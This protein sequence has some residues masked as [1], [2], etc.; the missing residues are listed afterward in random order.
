VTG[1]GPGLSDRAHI[2]PDAVM[3]EGVTVEPFAAIGDGV[4]LAS[5]VYVGY[6]AVVGHE[7]R[8]PGSVARALEFERTV[9]IGAGSVISPHS[10]IYYGVVI[11]DGVLIGD[12]A[13]IREG[14]R[15]GPRSLLSRNVTLN[16]DVTIGANVKVMDNTHLTGGCVVEDDVFISINVSTV[17]DDGMGR[18]GYDEERVVGPHIKRGAAIGASAVLLPGITIGERA[19]V[20]AGAVVTRD[21]P[22]DTLVLGT[23]ARPR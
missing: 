9:S 11:E 14:A 10:V 5:G 13:S 2:D 22:A 3:G 1:S 23:P 7:P 18:A 4:T 17:N 6:S 19:T 21:V 12:G 20:A 16:Y 15:I 8:N